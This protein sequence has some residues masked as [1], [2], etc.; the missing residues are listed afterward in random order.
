MKSEQ[1]YNTVIGQLFRQQFKLSIPNLGDYVVKEVND[2]VK[3]VIG[4]IEVK[5]S[6]LDEKQKNMLVAEL[7][8]NFVTSREFNIWTEGYEVQGNNSPAMYRGKTEAPN[9]HTACDLFFK[10]DPHYDKVNLTYWGCKLFDNEL[11]ARKAFG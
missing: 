6:Y 1:Y 2:I 3:E 8:E 7:K 4:Y 10:D 9:F 5:C 11:D